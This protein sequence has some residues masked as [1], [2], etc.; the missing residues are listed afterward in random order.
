[1]SILF[2][3][4]RILSLLVTWYLFLNMG[5]KKYALF[6]LHHELFLLRSENASKRLGRFTVEVLR[7]LQRYRYLTTRFM[8]GTTGL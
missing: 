4:V 6:S 7:L 3:G 8:Q 5:M 1:M 2:Y